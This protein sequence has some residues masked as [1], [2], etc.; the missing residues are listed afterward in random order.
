[1]TLSDITPSLA[2]PRPDQAQESL[3]HES[4]ALLGRE[5]WLY[6]ARLQHAPADEDRL[7]LHAFEMTSGRW[8]PLLDTGLDPCPLAGASPRPGCRLSHDAAGAR[9]LLEATTPRGRWLFS[10]ETAGDPLAPPR[11]GGLPVSGALVAQL[12]CDALLSRPSGLIGVR[13]DPQKPWRIAQLLDLDP[14]ASTPRDWLGSLA[15]ELAQGVTQAAVQGDRLLVAAADA[16]SGFSLWATPL[17]TPEPDWRCLLDRGAERYL[18]NREVFALCP[19]GETLYL[20]A[21][22][23]PEQR[24][25][26]SAFFDYQGFELLR[27]ETGDDWELLAGVPRVSP[28]G[29]KLPLSALGPGLGARQREWRLLHAQDS[30]LIL[31]TTDEEGLRLWRSRDGEDW[32]ALAQ[33]GLEQIQEVKRCRMIACGARQAVLILDTAESDPNQATRLWRL[34]LEQGAAS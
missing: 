19:L 27:L 26:E 5:G 16:E 8:H 25:P 13:R 4:L 12:A 30:Q 3:A 18:H 23:A 17:E 15:P 9:L 1:M 32:E 24:R 20:A 7:R 28:Q 10:Q 33:Q 34:D 14:T 31:G 29:L 11:L 22:T 6:L 2:P 21:G